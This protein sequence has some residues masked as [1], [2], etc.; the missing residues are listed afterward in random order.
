MSDRIAVLAEGRVEQVGAPPEIYARPATTYVAGFLGSANIFDAELHSVADGAASCT[1]LGHRGRPRAPTATSQPG[2][3]AIVI[4]PER[5]ALAAADADVPVGRN[6]L[7]GM[8]RDIV[9]L[10]AATHVHV[11]LADGA[12]LTVQ[13]ANEHG[14]PS[15]RACAGQR[16]CSACARRTPCACC[17]AARSR[18]RRIPAAA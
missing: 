15:V 18:R 16:P 1:V 17:A 3:A 12:V 2:P 7:R 6:V 11:E 13:V 8:V 14:P 5:I 9:Y 4:R 10:G